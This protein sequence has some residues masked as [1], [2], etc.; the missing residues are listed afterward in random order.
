MGNNGAHPNIPEDRLYGAQEVADLPDSLDRTREE[1]VDARR[2]AKY[3]SISSKKLLALARS[4]RVPAHGIGDRQRRMWRFH[5][6]ELN[7]WMQTEPQI[8]KKE[9]TTSVD[10]A[11]MPSGSPR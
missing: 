9:R 3:L 4:G 5:L 10:R 6:S 11:N 1:Y 7:H 8:A 2:A